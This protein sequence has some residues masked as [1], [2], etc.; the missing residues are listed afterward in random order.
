MAICFGDLPL[1]EFN[2]GF[3]RI[4]SFM[5]SLT[6]Y[7]FNSA[8][9]GEPVYINSLA[10]LVDYSQNYDSTHVNDTLVISFADE[11]TDLELT[12]FTKIG[13]AEAPFDGLIKVAPDTILNLS[14]RTGSCPRSTSLRKCS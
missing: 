7:A 14:I 12:G 5:N 3:K 1:A 4:S 10:D 11:L 9:T 6:S 13:T 8:T 2:S